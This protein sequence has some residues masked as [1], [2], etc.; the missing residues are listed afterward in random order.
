LN[1][2][3]LTTDRL[4]LR[5]WRD[6][7]LDALARINADPDVMRYILDGR[8]RTR[9]ETAESLRRMM[10]QWDEHGFGLFAVDIRET[11]A[12]AGWAGLAIPTFLPE[13]MPA[14]EIGWR[15]AR[16]LWGCGYATEAA[17][18]VMR[19]AFTTC[20]LPRLI[21]IRH[22]DNA[23]SARVMEKLG[24]PHAFDTVVPEHRQPVAVHELTREDYLA[25]VS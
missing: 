25:A 17:T 12:L 21:S 1:G 18:E 11:G 5:R 13:V 16:P 24:M 23:R 8:T 19:F 2:I 4:L 20:G 6:D 22:V 9:E 14:V 3:V 10:R 7:D 15:L